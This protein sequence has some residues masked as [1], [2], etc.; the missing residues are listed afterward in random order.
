[1]LCDP[2]DTLSLWVILIFFPRIRQ[3][4][5]N[6]VAF[7]SRVTRSYHIWLPSA[8]SPYPT[9]SCGPLFSLSLSKHSLQIRLSMRNAKKTNK[10]RN[11]KKKKALNS[12]IK[13]IQKVHFLPFISQ[14]TM[15]RPIDQSTNHPFNG[16]PTKNKTKQKNGEAMTTTTTTTT[17]TSKCMQMVSFCCRHSFVFS[18]LLLLFLFLYSVINN[19]SCWMNGWLLTGWLSGC[20]FMFIATTSAIWRNIFK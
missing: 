15:D 14:C 9:Y 18:L 20:R 13:T 4:C 12:R 19:H 17:I 1:M 3:H 7:S 10:R 6:A 16:D 11:G 2:S 8:T 5:K